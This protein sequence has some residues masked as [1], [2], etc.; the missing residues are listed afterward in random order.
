[1]LDYHNKIRVN[2]VFNFTGQLVEKNNHHV[3]AASKNIVCYVREKWC[4]TFIHFHKG[5]ERNPARWH[6]EPYTSVS[7]IKL[8]TI[9]SAKVIT[10][11]IWQ[12]TR[13]VFWEDLI[14]T[15]QEHLLW[16]SCYRNKSHQPSSAKERWFLI[17]GIQCSPP[18]KHTHWEILHYL[19]FLSS[20]LILFLS[21][22][23]KVLG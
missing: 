6:L 23:L 10:N 5:G 14:S 15:S 17:H 12:L 13:K 7:V 4:Y 8:S 20:L 1:M 9:T 18:Q 22:P 2:F 21:L 16:V 11:D 19:W 3:S